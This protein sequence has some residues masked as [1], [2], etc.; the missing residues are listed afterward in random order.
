MPRT[1]KERDADSGTRRLLVNTAAV[2]EE[3]HSV[4][5]QALL[6]GIA[7]GPLFCVC[8]GRRISGFAL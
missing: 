6:L 1:G 4:Y 3:R 8:G 7:L 2:V 5:D